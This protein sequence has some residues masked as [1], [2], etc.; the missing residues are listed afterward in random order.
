MN[1]DGTPNND[2]PPHYQYNQPQQP[3]PQ[4]FPGYPQQ[5]PP[6][7]KKT[8]LIVG[9][10]V[11]A[12]VLCG[13]CGGIG[14][15]MSHGSSTTTT[16]TTSTTS[17]STTSSAPTAAPTTAPTKASAPLDWKTTHS[18][19]GNGEKKTDVFTVGDTWK[20]QYTCDGMG[21]GI[22]GVLGVTVYGSD[23]NIQDLAVNAT[24]KDGKPT[25]DTTTE[26]QGGQIYLDINGSSDWTIDILEQK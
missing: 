2:Q 11:G 14:S 10:I 6:K 25:M 19:K 8:W 16:A 24:C 21:Q 17:S 13:L 7:K 1:N 20:I 9:I 12:L 18:F 15:M 3:Y 5:Q 26:H 23:G 22:D 4:G